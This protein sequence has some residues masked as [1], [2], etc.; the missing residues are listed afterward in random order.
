MDRH[1]DTKA[2]NS[3]HTLL[4]ETLKKKSTEEADRS[5]IDWSLLASLPCP[6]PSSLKMNSLQKH[7]PGAI[8]TNT[9]VSLSLAGPVL[10]Q[11]IIGCVSQH[12]QE[13][14]LQDTIPE[15]FD[16]PFGGYSLAGLGVSHLTSRMKSGKQLDIGMCRRALTA[17]VDF[18]MRKKYFQKYAPKVCNSIYSVVT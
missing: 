8:F 6:K 3:S 14:Y 16:E 5:E 2:D 4:K 12:L 18:M 1:K 15:L 10:S 9:G 17:G 7:K 11:K 13:H